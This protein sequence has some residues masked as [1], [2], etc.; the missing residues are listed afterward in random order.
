[1]ITTADTLVN[2]RLVITFHGYK[3]PWI[4][5]EQNIVLGSKYSLRLD[6]YFRDLNYC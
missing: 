3:I 1:M 4:N 5:G 2:L 6:H